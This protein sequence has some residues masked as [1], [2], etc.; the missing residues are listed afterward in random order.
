MANEVLGV[1]SQ[2]GLEVMTGLPAT[3]RLW[4]KDSH[5]DL[6]VPDEVDALVAGLQEY[7]QEAR[8]EGA[9]GKA[10]AALGMPEPAG[11]ELVE[12]PAEKLFDSGKRK[13]K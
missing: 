7:A 12:D 10:R 2:V 6:G 8:I 4:V 3:V 9:E 1:H 11:E 13:K 5:I